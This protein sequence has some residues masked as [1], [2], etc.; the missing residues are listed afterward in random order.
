MTVVDQNVKDSAEKIIQLIETD[1]NIQHCRINIINGDDERFS[2]YKQNLASIANQK[3]ISVRFYPSIPDV[4]KDLF[5]D[6]E[7]M[8]D[9]WFNLFVFNLDDCQKEQLM[10][11][12]KFIDYLTYLLK[13]KFDSKFYATTIVYTLPQE[14]IHKSFED[15]T[16]E[17]C[18]IKSLRCLGYEFTGEEI[19]EY[20]Y[21]IL[22]T[23]STQFLQNWSRV[24]NKL[25][26]FTKREEI[27]AY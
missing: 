15:F 18:P 10:C 6:K 22:Q 2:K 26:L 7:F 8:A 11:E 3:D 24:L 20:M 27:L 14:I 21:K 16:G 5:Q 19:M 13:D 1:P 12:I 9:N 4:E 23:H 25:E 17:V